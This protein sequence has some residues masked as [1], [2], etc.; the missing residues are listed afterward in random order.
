MY[1]KCRPI[2]KIAY[3]SENQIFSNSGLILVSYV[4]LIIF[5][6]FYYKGHNWPREKYFPILFCSIIV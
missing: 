3:L 4:L 1:S 5:S 6:L 2:R